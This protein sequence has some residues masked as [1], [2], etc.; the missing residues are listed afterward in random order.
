MTTMSELW[1]VLERNTGT[2]MAYFSGM[3]NFSNYL[4]VFIP[5][6]TIDHLYAIRFAR[7]EDAERVID[8]IKG[9]AVYEAIKFSSLKQ[10]MDD[11]ERI[12]DEHHAR[13]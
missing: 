5:V 13:T 8:H 12:Y 2:V 9:F 4:T 11:L 10:E 7:K 3:R 1:W 6:E